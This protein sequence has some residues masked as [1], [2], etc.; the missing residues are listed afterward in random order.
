MI[1]KWVG[2]VLAS[3]LGVVLLAVVGT[4]GYVSTRSG[5][6]RIRKLVVE[7]AN[8][9][10]AGKLAVETLSLHGGHLLLRGVTLND[11]EGATVAR[12]ATVE[13]RIALMQ[14]VHKRVDLSLVRIEAPELLL[15]SDESG[16]NLSRA[17]ASRH[18]APPPQDTSSGS[19]SLGFSVDD[20]R[21]TGGRV[22]FLQSADGIERHVHLDAFTA[23]GSAKVQGD[24]LAAN[25]TSSAALED[26]LTAPLRLVLKASGAHGQ[27]SADLSFAVG[28]DA[29]LEANVH[30]QDVEHLTAELRK[31]SLSP[32]LA[33]AFLPTYP[34]E[35]AVG[36]H[37]SATREGNV[38]TTR[39]H[40]AAG[41]AV[42]ALDGSV[43]LTAKRSDGITMTL[44]HADLRE[45]LGKGPKSSLALDV[46]AS[47]G[48]TSAQDAVGQLELRMP[49]SA[50]SGERMGPVHVLVFADRGTFRL[51][52]LTADVPGIRLQ[53]HGSGTLKSISLTGALTATDLVA[54]SKTLGRLVG[55]KGLL[56]KGQG[57]LAF[58]AEGPLKNPHVRADGAFPTLVYQTTRIERLALHADVPD[59][60][61]PAHDHVAIT[62]QRL[63]LA[64][65][66]SFRAV[67]LKLDGDGADVL[68]NAAVHGAAELSLLARAEVDG[69]GHGG[70]LKSFELRYPEAT[71]R[72]DAPARISLPTSGL[73]LSPLTLRSGA[74]TI[75]LRAQKR[76]ASLDAALA[77]SGL[78]L[79]RLPGAFVD[80]A[81]Q[82]GGTLNVNARVKGS[83]AKPD[84]AAKVDLLSGRFKKY[85]NVELHLDGDY[86]KDRARGTVAA[87]GAGV[88]LHGDFDVPVAALKAGRR[89][90]IRVEMKVAELRL[91]ESKRELGIQKPLKGTASAEL[92]VKGMTDNPRLHLL[93]TGHGIQ[94][95]ALP[96]ADL[97]VSVNSRED[98]ERH[99]IARID[100]QLEQR[101]SYVELKTP[102]SLAGLIAHPPSKDAVMNAVFA[103]RAELDAFPLKALTQ[104]GLASQP[105]DGTLSAHADVAGSAAA[106]HGEVSLSGKGLTT[107]GLKPVDLHLQLKAAQAISLSVHAEQGGQPLLKALLKV[108]GTPQQLQRRENLAAVPVSLDA[109]L[110][111]VAIADLQ[112]ATQPLDLDPADIP[113]KLSGSLQGKIAASGT[114][115]DPKVKLETQVRGLG[116]QGYPTGQVEMKFNYA[117]ARETLDLLMKST[118]GGQ[119]HVA[120]NA[121]LDLSY[122]A[123]T[124][125]K[126]LSTTPVTASLEAKDF[127]V[128]FLSNITSAVERLGGLIEAQAQLHGT[129][130]SP[131][132]LG[133]LEWK[134]G[135]LF[136]H[137]SGDFKFIH[138]LA[139]GDN[140]HVDLK[141]LT[142]KSGQGT[143][144][145]SAHAERN[146]SGFK[147]HAQADLGKFPV[148]SDGQLM[149][150]LSLRTTADAETAGSQVTVKS[151]NIPEA[152]ILLPDVH[153]KD[154]QKLEDPTDVLLTLNGKPVHSSSSKKAEKK[155]RQSGTGGAGTAGVSPPPAES[156]GTKMTLFV[157]AP[158]NLWIQG[159]DIDTEIGFSDGFRVEYDREPKIF[160]DV[161]VIRGR[162]DVVGRRFDLEKDSKVSF[163]GPILEP[164]LN[165]SAQYKNETE[166]IRVY[167]KA[168][169]QADKLALH[170]TSD[171]PLPETEIYTLLATGHTSMRHGT[172]QS[173]PSGQAASL[174]GG[175]AATQLKKT[176]ASKLPLDVLSIQAG[177]NGLSG[178]K[179]E[180]GT[181]VN[182]RFYVGFTGRIGA[183]PMRG[184]NANEVD[185]EYQ[186]SKYWSVNG[187]YGDARAGGTSVNW[188]KEY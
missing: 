115:H 129:L 177:D 62:A 126:N 148:M 104:A 149:A 173:S 95:N 82:L 136:T 39:L 171:P 35:V 54:F 75:S 169:G 60:K 107:S 163:T 110:G 6:E 25:L 30:M 38:V 141:E 99:L 186:L 137:G 32:E 145:L 117:S 51:P 9:T 56:V 135:T 5:G 150:T 19:S 53:A 44:R 24:A 183:D 68:L 152:H 166:Q 187:D 42:A 165:V 142:A 153:R 92:S 80:P 96:P 64:P 74:Q 46:H 155:A 63:T 120:A 111:P 23:S 185:L 105:L 176:L 161:N 71:W 29:A 167:I 188:R 178:S 131:A 91:D 112:A 182:D 118:N 69:N 170:P 94:A 133:Q 139:S 134:D 16:M 15:R 26:P 123:V 172:G 8:A 114:L 67:H 28:D 70:V 158:R 52:D 143:A 97:E 43:N 103:L 159:N 174:V 109:T 36:L 88:H 18:P 154:L 22:D 84:L 77:V 140:N 116:S 128:A 121:P 47:G 76:G 27:K 17:I 83:A 122:P 157:D 72:L 87:N 181:Y 184:E 48:G 10:I 81:L 164:N 7:K 73:Q 13:L 3:L 20:F 4:V 2:I 124:N 86:A 55:P 156:G 78:N 33:R 41:S 61:Q 160:G 89:E 168:Q 146:G 90:P 21:L 125:A 175:V 119:V 93:V 130:Q 98:A 65:K 14:L 138:L 162:L 127:D 180:A 58:S 50:M 1:L 79:A 179:L 11:P 101:K 66:R 102:F 59:V 12:V 45:L 113:P 151:V 49:V 85:S 132:L 40:L 106:P 108:E 31:L 147:L 144:K 100:V 37:G 34:L 57:Q